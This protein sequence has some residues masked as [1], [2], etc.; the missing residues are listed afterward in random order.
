MLALVLVKND[1]NSIGLNTFSFLIVHIVLI[2]PRDLTREL[3]CGPGAKA[4]KQ[5]QCD[6]LS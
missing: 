2:A 5:R 6:T 1:H 3:A 4:G